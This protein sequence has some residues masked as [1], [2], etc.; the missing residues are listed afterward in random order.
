MDNNQTVP[1][2]TVAPQTT[3]GPLPPTSQPKSKM[4]RN[5]ILLVLGI[6]I[7]I[8]L[9]ATGYMMFLGNKKT[10]TAQVYNQPTI[11]LQPTAT[12]T[13]SIYQVNP[14]DSSNSAIDKDNQA[15]DQS[16][17]TLDTDLNNVDQ[18]FNDQE[19]NLQ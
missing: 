6:L 10:Y 5:V 11:K 9:A 16:L 15:A 2:Q 14:K 4:G 8:I 19:T 3:I 18:S 12:P 7:I 17:N 1:I 13:P